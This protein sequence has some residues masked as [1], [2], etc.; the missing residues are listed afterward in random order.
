MTEAG[1]RRVPRSQC[2]HGDQ[3]AGVVCEETEE[4]CGHKLEGSLEENVL[5]IIPGVEEELSCKASC[6]KKPD[7]EAY[8]YHDNSDLLLPGN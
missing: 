5:E 2:S 8:T 1:G 7:C 6:K 4:Q 3:W